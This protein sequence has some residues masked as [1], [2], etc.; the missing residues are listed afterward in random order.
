MNKLTKTILRSDDL[1][2]PSCVTG[3]EA[4]LMRMDGVEKARVH[5]GTGRI[6][7]EHDAEAVDKQALVEVV[8]QAG[9]ESSVIP[10]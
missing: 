10:F 4:S 2:C 5:F 6:E 7:V 9:Y 1:S 8:R 3:I